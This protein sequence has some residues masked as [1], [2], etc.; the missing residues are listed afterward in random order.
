M[1]PFFK[2]SESG[3]HPL[4]TSRRFPIWRSQKIRIEPVRAFADPQEIQAPL[5]KSID[6][7]RP[8][9]IILRGFWTSASL[10]ISDL[11][12]TLRDFRE[13]PKGDISDA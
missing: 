12:Q 1:P 7:A 10:R 13:V 2:K 8:W 4:N 6:P 5:L 9:P 11:T 3:R